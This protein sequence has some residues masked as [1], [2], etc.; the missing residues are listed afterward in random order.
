MTSTIELV[1]AGLSTTN[2][3]GLG[4]IAVAF[5]GFAL[6]CSFVLP[7]RNPNFPGKGMRWFVPLCILFFLAMVAAVLVFGKEAK[8]A[9]GGE[10]T[11]EMTATTTSESTTPTSTASATPQG[12]PAAGKAV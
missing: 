1:A 10:Q 5:M 12:D 3:I 2:K 9:T 6:V 4:A 7:R 8:E 11:T